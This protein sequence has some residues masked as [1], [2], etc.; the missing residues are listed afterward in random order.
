MI[1]KQNVKLLICILLISVIVLIIGIC[2]NFAGTKTELLLDSCSPVWANSK[3]INKKVAGVNTEISLPK[4]AKWRT[5]NLNPKIT[6]SNSIKTGDTIEVNLCPEVNYKAKI[7]SISQNVNN[8]TTIRGRIENNPLSYILINNT[9]DRSLIEIEV[10]EQKQQF[11]I[12]ADQSGKDYLIDRSSTV[13]DE[14]ED[15]PT[16]TPPANQEITSNENDTGGDAVTIDVLVVYTPQARAWADSY[17]TGIDNVI[18]QAMAK[19][20]L[21]NDNSNTTM[22]FRLAHS[23]EINYTE[24]G[25]SITD[26]YRITDPDDG[27]MDEVNT[28]RNQYSADLVTILER[29]DDVGGVGWLLNSESGSP[30]YAFS[31]VRVQQTGWTYTMVHEMGHN[32]GAHHSKLQNFQPGP[33]LYDFSAGWRWVGGDG[34]KYCSVMTYE[35]G[36]YFADGQ[37]HTRAAYWSNPDITYQSVATGDASDGDNARTIRETKAVVSAYRNAV[38]TI[39]IGSPSTALTINGPVSYTISYTNATDITLNANDVTLNKTGTANGLIAVF[40]SGTETRTVT[41]SNITGIGTLGIS[42][43]SGT[44]VNIDNNLAPAAGPSTTFIAGSLSPIISLLSTNF[45]NGWNMSSFPDLSSGVLS[46]T[47]LPDTYK[48]RQYNGATNTY[49]KGENSNITL[50]PG[51]GYWIRADDANSISG[52][53]YTQ[54][55]VSSVEIPVTYGWNLL[56]NPYQSAIPLSNLRVKYINN[57]TQSFEDAINDSRVVGYV[58]SWEKSLNQYIFIAIHPDRYNTSA[59]KQTSINPYRGFWLLTRFRDISSIIINR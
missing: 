16:L 19:S 12:Q 59:T 29:V 38:P 11:I 58:W 30:D 10:P 25:N 56:G 50:T 15:S 23:A 24:S 9:S 27:Y 31:L 35:S 39:S 51:T 57:T 55:Q 41:I 34:G 44:A 1:I 37:T 32:L 20:Q 40:G 36:S 6:K 48:I 17:S 33:G 49:I 7:D 53:S 26:L 46:N 21:T 47:L 5:V 52:R 14:L 3:I 4:D 28:L 43:A 42:I 45:S 54:N 18:A 22:T 13:S 2:K 8:T